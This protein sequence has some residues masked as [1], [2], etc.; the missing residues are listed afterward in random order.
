MHERFCGIR[1]LF[2][3]FNDSI[4]LMY[5][6][7]LPSLVELYYIIKTITVKFVSGA[8]LVCIN[9]M[10]SVQPLKFKLFCQ[11]NQTQTVDGAYASP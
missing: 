1:L 8:G 6:S 4:R 10:L 3:L 7:F 5:I 2:R 11:K 9:F